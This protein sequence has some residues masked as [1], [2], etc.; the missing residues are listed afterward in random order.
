[1]KTIIL[2]TVLSLLSLGASAADVGL[3]IVTEEYP[4]YNYT[5]KGKFTGLSTEVVQAVLSELDMD[6]GF[7]VNEWEDSYQIALSEPHVLIFS[8]G[9]NQ[10][11][12]SLF[13][14]VGEITPNDSI[15]FFALR[16]RV[17]RNQIRVKDLETAKDYRIGTTKNDFREQYLVSKGFEV[18]EHLVRGELVHNNIRNLFWGRVDL[19]ALPKMAGF[20]LAKKLGYN[21]RELTTVLE[22][23]EI[24]PGANYMAFSRDTPDEMVEAFRTALD[25]VKQEGIYDKIIAKY[26]KEMLTAEDVKRIEK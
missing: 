7:E 20:T 12:E 16:S 2:S 14:W 21:P 5:E 25:K 18:G 15:H 8:I 23:S 19:V 1:M 22:L 9:R 10:E 4:P 6:A 11:R 3:R 17:D 24:P 13:K 26:R